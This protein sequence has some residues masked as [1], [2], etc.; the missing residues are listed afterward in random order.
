M[1]DAI[2]RNLLGRGVMIGRKSRRNVLYKTIRRMEQW[3]DEVRASLVKLRERYK[4]KVKSNQ[5]IMKA[6][7]AA[8]APS[9]NPSVTSFDLGHLPTSRKFA[10]TH[11]TIPAKPKY[12]L[13]KPAE[14]IHGNKWKKW[15]ERG[16]LK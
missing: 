8:R 2:G 13:V 4:Q 15:E 1:V 3:R 10:V 14:R 7:K 16:K 5:A 9:L 6:K 11:S 12:S